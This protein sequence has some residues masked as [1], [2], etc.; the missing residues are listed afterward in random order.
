GWLLFTAK[1]PPHALLAV[2]AVLMG[3]LGLVLFNRMSRQS[4][5][6]DQALEHGEEYI[7]RVAE[8][9][10]DIHAIIKVDTQSYLYV[11]QAVEILL[12]YTK[13]EF[14]QG[15]VS[16]F[17]ELVHPDDVRSVVHCWEKLLEPQGRFGKG[18]EAPQEEVYRIRNK[19]GE[20]RW[21]RSRRIIFAR[22]ADGRASEILAVAHDI[23]EQRSYE[24]ALVQAHEIESL[25]VLA[26]RLAH[27]LNNI[28][29]GIR[30]Y[31]DLGMESQDPA[32]LQDK[33]TKIGEGT[34]RASTLC[35][36]MLAYAGRGR[37]QITRH[38][39]NDSIREGLP[40]VESLV[41]ENVNLILELE[42]DLPKVNGD[43]NQVRFAMLNLVVNAMEAI[44]NKPGEITIAT[45]MKYMDGTESA[46]A[47]ALLGEY[48]YLEV[49]DS[50]NGMSEDTL[51]G[52]YDPFFS[53]KHPGR[54]VG[55]LSVQSIARE[56]SGALIAES[57]PGQGSIFRVFFPVAEKE[58]EIADDY[59]EGTPILGGPSLILLV[60]DEPTIR[61]I[62]RQGLENAGYKVI[63]AADGVDGF[64]AFVRHRSSISM[65]LLDLTMP[66]M[67][68]DEVF[69]EIHRLAPEVP[70][71]LMSGYSQREA[72]EAMNVVGLAGFLA[73]PFSV[74]EA[75]AVVNRVLGCAVEAP[76]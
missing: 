4:R 19:W 5:V 41:P 76:K 70:V 10:Q 46:E 57:V 69:S 15:G 35:R 20:Y 1:E 75:L 38:Q 33:L 13:E 37:V 67:G 28:L 22:N 47:S 53:V 31:V 30:G 59:D 44:G 8:L 71:V 48:V 62:L 61:S 21:L 49:R 14:L 45:A 54:G 68:G 18:R 39:L 42:N 72:T 11:N 7:E 12:G 52:I 29:M 43:P 27:D 17:K 50:S 40:L 51:S 65:V 26:R 16:F 64:G 60:D 24:A 25:G 73:K 32:N 63:E 66:R 9:S 6:A 2:S 3:A 34:D 74:R 58:P 56:H 55:M 23:T 36:Q